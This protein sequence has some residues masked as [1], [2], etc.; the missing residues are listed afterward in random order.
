MKNLYS[1]ENLSL[2]L[3]NKLILKNFSVKIPRG[4][5]SLIGTNGAGKTTF[6]RILAGL[7]RNYNGKIAL[8]STEMKNFSHKKIARCLSFV[9]SDKNFRPSYSFNVREIISLGRLPFVGMFGRLKNNDNDLIE[10]A[11]E[12]LK[13]SH[14][15]NRDI[16][17]LSDG[18]RKLAFIAAGIA[19][20]TE[21]ILL[22]EPTASLDPDKTA[23]VFALLKNLVKA[24]KCVITAVHD[25][26]TASAYSDFYIA[27]KNGLLVFNGTNLNE[28][29]LSE[30]Y[31][32]N[33]VTYFNS[34]RNNFM[35]RALKNN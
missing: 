33:F 31:D 4:L 22:D 1:I 35:W 13:I 20:D 23:S 7:E 11:A 21:I 17:T 29:I 19:Q 26:N 24:G 32:V 16:L 34:E 25:I 10:R 8:N 28:K 14:L 9:M 12:L 15:L 5:V 27:I 30:I 2:R 18:E 3:E 6:L